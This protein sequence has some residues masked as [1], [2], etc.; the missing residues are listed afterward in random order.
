VA[1]YIYLFKPDKILNFYSCNLKRG[2]PCCVLNPIITSI[3]IIVGETAIS[4]LTTEFE[5][6]LAPLR[7]AFRDNQL[8]PGLLQQC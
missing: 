2:A 7:V 3:E 5:E 1:A 4:S 8:L 6:L